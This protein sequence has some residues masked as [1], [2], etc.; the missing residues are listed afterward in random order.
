MTTPTPL[1]KDLTS[2]S[3][4]PD[5]TPKCSRARARNVYE[6]LIKFMNAKFSLTTPPPIEI[7][8]TILKQGN[9]FVVLFAISMALLCIFKSSHVCINFN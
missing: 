5:Q 6:F 3:G 4:L 9:W 7:F 1:K 8:Q 2:N